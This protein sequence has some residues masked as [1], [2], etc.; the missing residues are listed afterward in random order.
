MVSAPCLCPPKRRTFLLSDQWGAEMFVTLNFPPWPRKR[1]APSLR[2]QSLL[3]VG[4]G[5]GVGSRGHSSIWQPLGAQC[6][7][8]AGGAHRGLREGRGHS[9]CRMGNSK[10]DNPTGTD[11]RGQPTACPET[12]AIIPSPLPLTPWEYTEMGDP[13]H[14]SVLGL[15]LATASGQIL[16][17]VQENIPEL[18]D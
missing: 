5:V 8:G 10:Q 16:T 7:Q 12:P 6:Q 3:G 15:T 2:M 9:S 18:H 4:G 13:T 14:R 17:A 11:S 1:P